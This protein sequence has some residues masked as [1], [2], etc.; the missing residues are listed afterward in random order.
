MTADNPS[1]RY[2]FIAFLNRPIAQ[3]D[4]D[5]LLKSTE[6]RVTALYCIQIVGCFHEL[7]TVWYIPNITAI[8]TIKTLA[9]LSP[10]LTRAQ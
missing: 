7:K 2:R 4:A 10:Y 8:D 5:R 1:E 3:G 9:L 6:F